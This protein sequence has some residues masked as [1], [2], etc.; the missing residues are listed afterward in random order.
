MKIRFVSI[1]AKDLEGI[2]L[3]NRMLRSVPSKIGQEIAKLE[4]IEAKYGQQPERG[5]RKRESF[6]EFTFLHVGQKKGG[7]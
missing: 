4:I 3:E 5:K 6:F 2:K 7:D 1:A